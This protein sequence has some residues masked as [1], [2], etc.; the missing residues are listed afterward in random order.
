MHR[1]DF[2]ISASAAGLA[3]AALAQPADK[4]HE[5]ETKLKG[6]IKQSACRWCYGKIPLDDLC[7]GAAEIGLKSVEL[8]HP[9]EWPT[10]RKHGLTCA[11]ANSVK[12]NPIPRGFNRVELHDQII[13][14]LEE[15]LPMVKEAG[16]PNQI[17]FSG[18]R[19]GMDDK[20]GL[21]NCVKGL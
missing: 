1:R 9:E 21:V 3:G 8:L 11:V 19:D 4:P 15:R 5:P 12:S 16:I 2:L 10:T 13:K 20:T 14:E 6:R 17:C 7:A 18:N